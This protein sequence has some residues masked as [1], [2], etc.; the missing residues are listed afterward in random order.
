MKDW[1]LLYF[2]D[3]RDRDWRPQL[4]EIEAV[5]RIFIISIVVAIMGCFNLSE[6]IGLPSFRI[7]FC[8]SSE[9]NYWEGSISPISLVLKNG[10]FFTFKCQNFAKSYKINFKDE[11]IV[12]LYPKLYTVQPFYIRARP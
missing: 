6:N 8:L 2:V 7:A 10:L 3:C 11:I 4:G 9:F 12:D 5:R 1:S